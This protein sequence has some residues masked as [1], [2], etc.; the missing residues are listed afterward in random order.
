M[1]FLRQL[2][3]RRLNR[4]PKAGRDSGIVISRFART[5]RSGEG[6]VWLQLDEGLVFR[7]NHIGARIWQGLVEQKEPE[8]IAAEISQEYG[9]P[10]R[11]VESDIAAFL[12]DLS[13]QR[14]IRLRGKVA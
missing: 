1:G 6:I 13:A 3:G 4:Q 14:L 12:Q 10:H 5:S 11:E 9:V 8:C 2:I 7:A